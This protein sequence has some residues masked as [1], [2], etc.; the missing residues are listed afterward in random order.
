M[1]TE[2]V[3]NCLKHANIKMPPYKALYEYLFEMEINLNKENTNF[4]PA[5]HK[6]I[7]LLKKTQ[8]GLNIQLKLVQ[9][10]QANTANK[11]CLDISFNDGDQVLLNI[12]NLTLLCPNKKLSEKYIRL[13]SVFEKKGK[14]AYK[15][16]LPLNMKIHLIFHVNLLK[17]H[18]RNKQKSITN[19]EIIE[20]VD[21]KEYEVESILDY[22]I[23]YNKL[24]YLVKWKEWSDKYNEWLPEKALNRAQKL[25]QS[26]I[27]E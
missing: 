21:N 10:R 26:F 14:A 19:G 5:V 18:H 4:M 13:F 16:E 1:L 8:K 24:N 12:K 15:L 25:L 17:P 3:Y 9:D 22:C 11:H 6:C 2:F 20:L 7:K 27:K 23:R